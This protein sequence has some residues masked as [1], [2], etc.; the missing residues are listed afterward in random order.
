[1][2]MKLIRNAAIVLTL[3]AA[4]AAATTITANA[5]E[6]HRPTTRAATEVVNVVLAYGQ[7]LDAD[8]LAGVQQVY[9]PDAV[10]AP[11]GQPVKKGAAEVSK[12][13]EDLFTAADVQITFTIESVNVDRGLAYV[14]SHSNGVLKFKDGSPDAGG[15]GR[16]LFVLRNT[17]GHWKIV[18]YWFNN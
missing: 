4:A 17:D 12:F 8:D 18:A 11:P 14:T 16:E 13:Y 9:A 6:G 15:V 2:I 3:A 5:S 10:V 1:M 7:A